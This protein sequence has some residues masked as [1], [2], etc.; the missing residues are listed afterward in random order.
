MCW[1]VRLQTM[2]PFGLGVIKISVLFLYHKLFPSDNFRTIIFCTME[3]MA[4]WRLHA[5]FAFAFQCTPGRD[6]WVMSMWPERY[7]VNR[8]ALFN[9]SAAL[10]MVSDIFILLYH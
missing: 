10:S 9:A 2:Y 1:L 4:L 5:P 6:Y 3:S 8:G 7:C